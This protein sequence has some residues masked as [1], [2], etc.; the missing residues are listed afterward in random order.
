MD[1]GRGSG[2]R[3]AALQE[4]HDRR[5]RERPAPNCDIQLLDESQ[6]RT[7]PRCPS[8]LT[9]PTGRWEGKP[10]VECRGRPDW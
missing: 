5:Q 9:S 8:T 4:L 10:P 7:P 2:Q 6:F 3:E 1:I